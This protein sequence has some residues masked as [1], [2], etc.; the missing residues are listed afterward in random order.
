MG[1]KEPFHSNPVVVGDLSRPKQVPSNPPFTAAAKYFR[2][3][4]CCSR[5]ISLY[6]GKE[7]HQWRGNRLCSLPQSM[8]IEFALEG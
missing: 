1:F 8:L 3:N 7:P 6:P 4:A 2:C 5:R